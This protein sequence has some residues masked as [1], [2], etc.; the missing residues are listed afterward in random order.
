M[1][2][3]GPWLRTEHIRQKCLGGAVAVQDVV[4]AAFFEIDHEL[5]GDPC[6]AGPVRMWRIAAVATEIPGIPAPGHSTLPRCEPFAH[7]C[8]VP[9][10]RA[11]RGSQVPTSG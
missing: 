10:C 11:C 2:L 4:L 5:H 9:S 1:A 8:R 6:I 3:S 7:L